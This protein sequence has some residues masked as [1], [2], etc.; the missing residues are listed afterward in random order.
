[1]KM[2]RINMLALALLVLPTALWAQR[3]IPD[4]LPKFDQKIVHFGFQLGLSQNGF[5]LDPDITQTD[6]LINLQVRSQPGFVIHVVGELHFGPYIGLRWTP[7]IAFAA[8]DLQ[9]QFYGIDGPELTPTVRTIESTFI[10]SPLLIKYRSKRVNNFASYVMAGFNYSFDLA[11]QEHVDNQIDEQG[12]FI[13]KLRRS[14]YNLDVG[15]G[16]DFFLEYFK[17]TPELKFSYGLN[18]IIVKDNTVF[19]NPIN[20]LRSR[21]FVVALNFEG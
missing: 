15:V 6:S 17:F 18:N 19:S 14:N 13:V 11:S 16:F 9:Y 7:G 4:N 21:I 1:M 3:D 20:D 8:R 10:E 5:A 12:E 2:V